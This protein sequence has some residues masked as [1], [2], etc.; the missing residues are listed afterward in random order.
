MAVCKDP[1]L[2]YLNDAGYNVVRLPRKG[3]VPLGVLGKEKNVINYLGTLDEIWTS[4]VPVPKV[5]DPQP[6]TAL[7]GSKTSDVKLSLGLEILANAL[8]GMFG[9]T[10][11]STSSS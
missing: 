10:V 5:G 8:S 4:S 3:I 1:R 7:A 11:P 9:S 2:T 6:A